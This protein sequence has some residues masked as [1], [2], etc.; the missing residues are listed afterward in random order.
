MN[1]VR[2]YSLMFYTSNI[3]INERVGGLQETLTAYGNIPPGAGNAS[4][5]PAKARA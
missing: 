1:P 2:G 3:K 5:L 4:Y